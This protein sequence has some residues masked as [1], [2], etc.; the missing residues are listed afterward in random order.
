MCQER[1]ILLYQAGRF[2][3][4]RCP[5]DEFLGMLIELTHVF[6]NKTRIEHA[7]ASRRKKAEQGKVVTTPPVGLQL[8][9]DG[10][11]KP[12]DDPH[13][14]Q[15]FELLFGKFLDLRSATRLTRFL[16]ANGITLP[17]K[18]LPD[19]QRVRVDATVSRVVAILRNPAY[20]GIYEYGKTAVS[21][22]SDAKGR[23]R[24]IR[25]PITARV[26]K[27]GHEGFIDVQTWT[28]IQRCL[29]ANR[30][31]AESPLGKG[32]ALAQGRVRC[33]RHKGMVVIYPYRRSMP[34][35]TVRRLAAY[36]CDVHPQPDRS[37]VCCAIPARLVDHVVERQLL[38]ELDP[39]SHEDLREVN[40]QD[41]AS[42][43]VQV[44]LREE[45]LRRAEQQ[46]TEKARAV[47]QLVPA[48]H[49]LL[50]RRLADEAE[51]E[52]RQVEKIRTNH[53]SH[54][55]VPPEP[56]DDTQLDELR[57]LRADLP[58]AWRRPS[59]P[60]DLRKAIARALIGAVHLTPGTEAWT[61]TIEWVHQPATTHELLRAEGIQR[62]VR[63][64]FL[65]GF[66]P[67]EI[68]ERL[69]QQGVLRPMGA[70]AGEPYDEAAV[71]TLLRKMGLR[72]AVDSETYHYIRSRFEAPAT[73]DAIA[74]ELNAKSVAHPLGEWTASRVHRA[75]QMLREGHVPGVE[76]LYRGAPLGE[77]VVALHQD[78]L[79]PREIAQR[80]TE[81]GV[82]TRRRLP[83]TVHRVRVILRSLGLRSNAAVLSSRLTN[84]LMELYETLPVSQIARRLNELGF[85]TQRG[86]RWNEPSLYKKLHALGIPASKRR[87]PGALAA[88][89]EKAG[90]GVS[91]HEITRRANEIGLRTQLGTP[92]TAPAMRGRLA[93]LRIRPRR[94]RG[95]PNGHGSR[96]M[97]GATWKT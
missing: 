66:M 89:V 39:P 57:R 6:T 31:T 85:R 48:A 3:D 29:T 36:R 5:T 8:G 56:F 4:F 69:T 61:V 79:L 86:K 96:P 54:P 15:T 2:I 73:L 1:D 77:A 24:R 20:A 90:P 75:V 41:V 16:L 46:A 59:V 74:R 95:E 94:R 21:E 51:E 80:L 30:L 65:E 45:E 67:T 93:K 44:R 50:I 87:D 26:R 37:A 82:R 10:R 23:K 97:E 60:P 43:E 68:V 49:P 19:G 83:V 84:V 64:D 63:R 32:G 40:E 35:G 14:R 28:E 70:Y 92:W 7:R 55:L 72:R 52:C 33:A 25:Q 11:L 58:A 27:D 38:E 81:Q 9:L 17:G 18:R 12:D 91:I 22:D 88:L 76:R 42:Y 13:I 34:D 47:A 53:L 78:G 62:L 71:Q